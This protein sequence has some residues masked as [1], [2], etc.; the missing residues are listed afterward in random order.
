[1][2]IKT[3][4]GRSRPERR[5]LGLIAVFPELR[6]IVVFTAGNYGQDDKSVCFSMI[7]EFVLPALL[8]P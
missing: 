2:D 5:R 4:S 7:T 8:S 3:T 6:M 1:M